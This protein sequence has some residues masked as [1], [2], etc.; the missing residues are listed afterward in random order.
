M[1]A[2][3]Q[4]SETGQGVTAR[5][6]REGSVAL[7]ARTATDRSLAIIDLVLN[8]EAPLN[9]KTIGA[10]LELPKATVHR[11]LSALEDKGLVAKD[12]ISGGFV[13][14]PS[15]CEMAFK[16]L[17]KSAATADR[18]AILTGLSETIGETCNLGILDG[19]QA[20]YI[21]RIELENLP[22]RL[23]F[24]PGSR[25]PLYCSAM[26]KVFL[27]HMP[28]SAVDRYL[29]S[30]VRLPYTSATLIDEKQLRE[31][32]AAAAREGFATDDEEYVAGVNC[33][34]VAVPAKHARNLIALAVQAPKSRKNLDELRAF[35]PAM[36]D[37]AQKLALIL[38]QEA[39]QAKLPSAHRKA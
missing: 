25:V 36:T 18:H 38:D 21:D 8:S 35:L 33:L 5:A 20:R 22:L 24:R 26:G 32:I 10:G 6:G 14:G 37:A 27:S 31:S 23:D 4:A 1:A 19:S 17:R 15:L 39:A 9:A 29:A 7:E 30:V 3:N 2:D 28:A 13:A 16:I 12:P 11:L 34:A